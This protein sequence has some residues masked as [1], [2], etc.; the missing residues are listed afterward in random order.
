MVHRQA[1]SLLSD[2]PRM[3]DNDCVLCPPT[4]PHPRHGSK[5]RP[6][7]G[8][9]PR[10]RQVYTKLTACLFLTG[11]LAAPSGYCVEQDSRPCESG[12]F[13]RRHGYR[14]NEGRALSSRKARLRRSRWAQSIPVAQGRL[15]ETKRT[16]S[17]AAPESELSDKTEHIQIHHY[18]RCIAHRDAR[19]HF[20]VQQIDQAAL[21]KSPV[22]G[23]W[24]RSEGRVGLLA[25][26]VP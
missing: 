10:L 20:A 26:A 19:H 16:R 11:D 4:A 14:A 6:T 1:D 5:L 17:R 23:R 3:A 22:A 13:L 25:C 21:G 9:D 24:S 2:A 8:F 18:P 15:R 7:R 12:T